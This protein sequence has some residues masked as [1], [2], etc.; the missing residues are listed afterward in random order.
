MPIVVCLGVVINRLDEL[1]VGGGIVLLAAKGIGTVDVSVEN[2]KVVIS[3][4]TKS[5]YISLNV[6]GSGSKRCLGSRRC[7]VISFQ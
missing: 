7:L 3:E 5:S 6:Q 4:E 2:C 1:C